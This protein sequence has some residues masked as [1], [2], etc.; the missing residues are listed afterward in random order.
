MF[1]LFKFRSLILMAHNRKGQGKNI[2]D[3]S[4][5]NYDFSFIYFIIVLFFYQCDWKKVC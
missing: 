1:S 5:K 4:Y 2:L 3:W